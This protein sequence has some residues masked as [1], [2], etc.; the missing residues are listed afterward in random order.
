MRQMFFATT[1]GIAS[2]SGP[3]FT[4]LGNGTGVPTEDIAKYADD[5]GISFED[6]RKEMLAKDEQQMNS[7][8]TH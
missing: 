6:A 4:N 1:L 5:H 2:C 3:T 8:P 7:N